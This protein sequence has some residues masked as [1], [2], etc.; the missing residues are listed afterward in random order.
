MAF[1]RIIVTCEDQI[2]DALSAS[3]RAWHLPERFEH[4]YQPPDNAEGKAHAA[5]TVVNAIK[6]LSIPRGEIVNMLLPTCPF[7]KPETISNANLVFR[8]NMQDTMV[9]VHAF[10]VKSVNLRTLN[11]VGYIDPYPADGTFNPHMQ[12]AQAEQ[13]FVT[14]G[15]LFIATA[16]HLAKYASFHVGN[17]RPYV[18]HEFECVDVDT[19]EEFRACEKLIDQTPSLLPKNLLGLGKRYD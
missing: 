13:L 7:R 10:Q 17:V 15:A 11:E 18:M 2:V 19:N 9:G 1:G 12:A 5:L 3:L 16:S 8:G 14:A 6:E 4:C